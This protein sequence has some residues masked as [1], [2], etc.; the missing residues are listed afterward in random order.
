[1]ANI[2]I[3]ENYNTIDLFCGCGGL[4]KGL[5]WT[6]LNI[7]VGIDHWDKAIET[8]TKN[9]RHLGICADIAQLSPE[10]LHKEYINNENIDVIV[11]GPPCQGFSMAGKRDKN[12]P[13]NSL[14]MEY[15]RYLEYYKPKVFLF[16]NVMGIL[17][18]KTASG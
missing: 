4:S 8:Y 9:N 5:Q 7:L 6:G 18:M 12:D 10:K 2:R 3:I 17:S 14:F 15:V 11:G 1:M 13:R 16:E